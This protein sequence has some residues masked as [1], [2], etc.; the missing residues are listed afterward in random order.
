MNVKLGESRLLAATSGTYSSMSLYALL[1]H[2]TANTVIATTDFLPENVY[3][4]VTLTRNNRSYII[5]NDNLLVLGVDATLKKGYHEFLNGFDKTY[6]ASGVKQIKLRTVVIDWK[7]PIRV[8]AGDE[9]TA[10]VTMATG[11][12]TSNLDSSNS[13]LDF[14]FNKAIGYEIGIPRIISRTIPVNS[15][16]AEFTPGDHVT[17]VAL[18]NLDKTDLSSEVLTTLNL[19]SDRLDYNK[20]FNQLLNEMPTTYDEM[21]RF[22]FGTS[23]PIT[24][25]TV[26]RGLDYLPQSFILFDGDKIQNELADCN[27]NI[28]FNSANVAASKNFLVWH[29]YSTDEK[30]L[31]AAQERA[32]KHA[33]ENIQ[34]V[35]SQ[36][37]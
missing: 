10:E 2:G 4:K 36:S 35:V 23:L 19:S 11:S 5:C 14:S 37:K 31:L 13:L 27:V 26:S 34:A 32:T 1:T 20:T 29:S 21:P 7:L 25:A 6:A 9:L 17:K 15:T 24:S 18:L 30:T 16:N 22:R 3:I 12:L 28:A 33:T 8:G